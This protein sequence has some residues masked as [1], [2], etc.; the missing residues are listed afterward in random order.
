MLWTLTLTICAASALHVVLSVAGAMLGCLLAASLPLM[1][2]TLF[3]ASYTRRSR[4]DV[5]V[6]CCP[7]IGS[8]MALTGVFILLQ[9]S[10]LLI[11]E[12]SNA[13]LTSVRALCARYAGV[14]LRKLP[15][16]V[17]MDDAFVKT[18]WEGGEL[19]CEA[20][21][22]LVDCVTAFAA[23]PVF[24][25]KAL[26]DVGSADE[27]WAWAVTKGEHVDAN[28]R[29]DGSFCGYLAGMPDFDFYLGKYALAVQRVIKKHNLQLSQKV[30]EGE[31]SGLQPAADMGKS[32]LD[33]GLRAPLEGRPIILSVDPLEIR[34]ELQAMLVAALILLCG[35]PCVG[36]LPLGLLFLYWCWARGDRYSGH[37]VVDADDYDDDLY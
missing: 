9:C 17:C 25:T 2:A 6:I 23:A 12:L 21:A 29:V 5:P 30:D 26:A 10:V 11:A 7:W 20:E 8:A 15:R 35:C 24:N 31:A 13:N 4:W 28:Y 27:I 14:P 34:Y 3:E 37:R 33:V 1:F 22:G 36:P 19:E 16:A 18:D 32:S